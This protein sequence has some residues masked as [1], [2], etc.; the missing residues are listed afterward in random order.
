M[1][2]FN[3]FL[4]AQVNN[5]YSRADL[6]DGRPLGNNFVT[7]L[8]YGHAQGLEIFIDARRLD[9]ALGKSLTYRGTHV[10]ISAATNRGMGEPKMRIWSCCLAAII[11]LSGCGLIAPEYALKNPPTFTDYSSLPAAMQYAQRVSAEIDSIEVETT[12]L[13]EGTNFALFGTA[14]SA[15]AVA[16]FS[17]SRDAIVGL[18]LGGAG[19][20]GYQYETGVN[21][22][23]TILDNARAAITC[24][25][26]SA[27]IMSEQNPG[28]I[29]P[30]PP[31]FA[32]AVVGAGAPVPA[33]PV[34]VAA[35]A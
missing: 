29:A 14:I 16:T 33:V 8:R 32:P 34:P 1:S 25:E 10:S 2:D 26:E 4:F 17:A 12:F 22:K 18:G 28:A 35:P 20:L 15:A 30:A 9:H 19:L 6:P 31:I 13:R 21:S 27:E 23:Q 11:F 5:D 24:A 7:L 3:Q